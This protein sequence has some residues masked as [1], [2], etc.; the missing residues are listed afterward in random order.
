MLVYTKLVDGVKKLFGTM[1]NIPSASDEELVYKDATG[2]V[3]TLE[4]KDSYVDNK[5]GGII[6]TSDES[7]V[8]VFIG[9]TQI[10]GDAPI[11]SHSDDEESEEDSE[12]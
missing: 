1:E 7:T 9:D 2:S 11:S 3:I 5:H 4:D 10:I 8:N 6:R 12:S